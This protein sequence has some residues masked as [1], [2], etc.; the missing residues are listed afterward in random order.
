LGDFAKGRSLV[1]SGLAHARA[2][3]DRRTVAECL[4]WLSIV[5][6]FQGQVEE[7][8]HFSRESVDIYRAIGAQAELAYSLTMLTGSFLLQGQFAEARSH[9]LS[10]VQAYEEMGLRH[11]Y[12]TMARAW[13]GLVEF[14]MGDYE[15]ARPEMQS[16]LAMA[17]ETG[18]KRGEVAG[19]LGC[20]AIRLVEGEPERALQLLKESAASSQ[21]I[22]QIDDYAWALAIMGYAECALGRFDQ[23]QDHLFEALR[24][25]SEM[26]AVIPLAFALPGIALLWASCGQAERAVELYALALSMPMVS[27]SPWF[28]DAAG[29]HIKAAAARLPPDTVAAA[30]TRGRAGDLKSTIAELLAEL[31]AKETPGST[32]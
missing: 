19:P 28:E 25:S 16:T 10:A 32:N 22:N 23:A 18:W 29:R 31:G 5:A 2:V 13:L 20:G 3:G 24:I 1:E 17:R 21:A 30:Q 11:A 7:S 12:S 4:Q 9:A 26:G 6:F 14:F 27:N 8:A 15:S